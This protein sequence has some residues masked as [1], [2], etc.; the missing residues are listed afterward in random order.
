MKVCVHIRILAIDI[1]YSENNLQGEGIMFTGEATAED[2][3]KEEE[4]ERNDDLGFR[5]KY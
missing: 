4:I 3:R 5:Q 1:F 2:S